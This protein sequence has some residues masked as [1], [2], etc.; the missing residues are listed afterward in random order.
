MLQEILIKT[1]YGNTVEQ[2]AYALLIILGAV[3]V[4]KIL[5]WFFGNVVKKFASKTKTKLDDIIVDMIEEPIVFALTLFGIWY[6][7][8]RLTLT[9][10][11][12][13]WFGNVFQVLIV[14]NVAWLITRL[15]DSFYTEYL[16]PL[17]DKTDTD[18]D[19]QI[20]PIVKTG[21]NI[22]IW[23]IAI[24]VA[25]NNAGYNVGALLAGLGIGGLALAMAAKDTVSN[26]FGGITIFVDKPF[27]LNDRVKVSGYD[28]T[29]VE[30]GLRSSRLKTLEGRIVTIPN[31]SFAGN[32]VENVT[33][34]PSRKVVLNLGLTY[35]TKPA[36]MEKAMKLLKDIAKKNKKINK[37]FKLS[38]NAFG[39]S[40]LGIMFIY[41]IKKS[42]DILE[43][44][45]EMNMEILKQF[46][47]NKLEFA[48]PTQTVYTV[49]G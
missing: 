7:T 29:I 3:V 28:G 6:A 30:I 13:A 42:S 11:M 25:L 10:G 21:T 47:K 35:D 37:D 17:A 31:S 27:K 9:E 2:W 14:I 19:D 36:Q 41:Y 40:A 18:L 16:V 4:G 15:F 26:V 22:I 12:S 8:T 49:K 39:D 34:E 43:T 33:R 32:P 44:Q 5:Y 46:N 24:L 20:L 23:I 38:F 1:Y 45:T 48:Y